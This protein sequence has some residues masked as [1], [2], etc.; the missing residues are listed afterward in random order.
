M[1]Q[2]FRDAISAGYGFDEPTL[3]IGSAMHDDELFNDVRVAVP[4]STL[5]RHG[6]VAGAT[7]TGKTKTLQLLAGPAVEGRRA[8]LR[9]RHQGRPDGPGGGR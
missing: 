1:D 7:G 9:R 5:N 2:A 3:I 4:M 8:G 6:L